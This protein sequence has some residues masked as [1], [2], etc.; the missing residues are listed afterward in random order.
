VEELNAAYGYSSNPLTTPDI[1]DKL[2]LQMQKFTRLTSSKRRQVETASRECELLV[3]EFLRKAGLEIAPGFWP[4]IKVMFNKFMV[5]KA[6]YRFFYEYIRPKVAVLICAFDR[7]GQ[8]AGTLEAGVSVVEIQHGVIYPF[9][10]GYIWPGSWAGRRMPVP[11]FIL[12]QNKFYRDYLVSPLVEHY[13]S[14]PALFSNVANPRPFWRGDQILIT[15]NLRNQPLSKAASSCRGCS[16]DLN[17]LITSQSNMAPELALFLEDTLEKVVERKLNIRFTVKLHPVDFRGGQSRAWA[18]VK[19]R[20][21][22]RVNVLPSASKNLLDIIMNADIHASIA[23][24]CHFDSTGV[25]TPTIV[26]DIADSDLDLIRF[27]DYSFLKVKSSEDF[28]ELL[29]KAIRNEAPWPAYRQHIS[30]LRDLILPSDSLART[31]SAL[32]LILKRHTS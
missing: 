32:G 6:A 22:E 29:Q 7:T 4:V 17:V 13:S 18:G 24:T 28:I 8:V 10:Y 1:Y 20:F 30:R 11:E 14:M 27:Q 3:S 26:L 9:H 2:P 23:S 15:G 16:G 5:T 19:A 21:P 31:I 12:V 25:G